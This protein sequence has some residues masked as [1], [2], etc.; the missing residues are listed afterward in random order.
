MQTGPI[1]L[2]SLRV[3]DGQASLEVPLLIAYPS[4]GLPD[5]ERR[6]VQVSIRFRPAEARREESAARTHKVRE[7]DT[8]YEIGKR[9]GVPSEDLRKLNGLQPGEYIQPG[10]E[11]KIPP[12][13]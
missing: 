2:Q 13:R 11:L 1:D 7:G 12:V 9:Y 6:Q 4:M 5:L 3:R 10:Q 8:L